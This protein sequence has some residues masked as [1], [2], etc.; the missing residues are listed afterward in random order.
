VKSLDVEHYEKT[1]QGD[2]LRGVL[3]RESFSPVFGDRVQVFARL[4]RPGYAY[5]VAFRPDGVADLCFPNDVDTLPPLT[6][7]PRYPAT[8]NGKA[9][10]LREG[11][12]LW[13]FAVLASEKP[14]PTYNQWLAGRKPDW[15]PEGSPT[16]SVWW[17]DGAELE[18][19]REGSS[20]KRGKD[21]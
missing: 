11:T 13:V 17:Y 10:G 14:L 5:V 12:G 8:D 19:L 3:G 1:L 16:G 20:T 2:V 9:Y 21:E 6:D 18:T 15:K 4:S 7:T